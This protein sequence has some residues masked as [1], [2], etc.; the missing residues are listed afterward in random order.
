VQRDA[1]VAVEQ[2]QAQ[3]FRLL[4]RELDAAAH[5]RLAV[6]AQLRERGGGSTLRQFSRSSLASTATCTL[7]SG[8]SIAARR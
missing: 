5:Q 4:G 1:G 6:L 8:A 2:A 3:V 7:K